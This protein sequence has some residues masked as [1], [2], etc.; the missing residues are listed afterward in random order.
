MVLHE[1]PQIMR[2]TIGMST[3]RDKLCTAIDWDLMCC[4]KHELDKTL[5]ESVRPIKT[6]LLQAWLHT[7]DQPAC[8][9]P[10]CRTVL[11]H[12]CEACQVLKS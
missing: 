10:G 7:E 8:K 5:P 12:Q 11:V 1:R 9:T 3:S 6:M 2:Q 4:L